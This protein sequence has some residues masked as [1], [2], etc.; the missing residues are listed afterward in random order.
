MSEE[1]PSFMKLM[2]KIMHY[3]PH[4]LIILSIL[5]WIIIALTSEYYALRSL[6]I[7]IPLILT[8][9]FLIVKKNLR[10]DNNKYILNINSNN[11][12]KVVFI[13][14]SLQFITSLLVGFTSPLFLVLTVAVYIVIFFQI[15]AKAPI[16]GVVLAEIF[17]TTLIL[18]LS[19]QLGV[20]LWYGDGDLIGHYTC[21]AHIAEMG[22]VSQEFYADYVDGV[23]KEYGIFCLYHILISIGILLFGLVP[24][25]SLYL[26][27]I[28]AILISLFFVYRLTRYF[29]NS[30][31]AALLAALFYS[32]MPCMLTAFLTPAPRV[33]VSAAF[34]IVLYIAFTLYPR[35][36]KESCIILLIL[37][38]YMALV[39]HA[40]HL[41]I[42]ATLSLLILGVILY[43]WGDIRRRILP[44]IVVAFI[45]LITLL[46]GYGGTLTSILK[47]RLFKYI[48]TDDTPIQMITSNPTTR[49]T[50]SQTVSDGSEVIL[51]SEPNTLFQTLIYVL[52]VSIMMVFCLI[53]IY[54]AVTKALHVKKIGIL[55]PFLLVLFIPFLPGLL[56]INIIISKSLQLYRLRT[57]IAPIFAI[58]LGVGLN[59]FLTNFKVREGYISKYLTLV[60]TILM[61]VG[62]VTVSGLNDNNIMTN[63]T[64]IS[65]A[66]FNMG[67]IALINIAPVIP[68]MD[69]CYS[70]WETGILLF[71]TTYSNIEN[72]YSNQLLKLFTIKNYTVSDQLKYIVLRNDRYIVFGISLWDKQIANEASYQFVKGSDELHKVI[73]YENIHHH[74]LVYDSHYYEVLTKNIKQC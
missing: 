31:Q 26:V 19:Q 69:G 45:S 33:M 18:I 44:L 73:F 72:L 11:L 7:F 62:F 30:S 61:I 64:E 25:V 10:L 23:W 57:L 63:G 8:C 22:E 40:Q 28:T 47:D 2:H 38:C 53:G 52:P 74:C 37:L 60:L 12:T 1:L 15:L 4:V 49:T 48:P 14:I 56:D 21:G 39:H 46:I 9:I 68:H 42:L 24:N 6:L 50:I 20:A 32:I 70:D 59:L 16:S 67:E 54:Y 13:F 65:P 36:K 71:R 3:I 34:L 58:V 41:F 51:S 66:L 29:F 5:S 43:Y 27:S 35:Y 55:I 17:I